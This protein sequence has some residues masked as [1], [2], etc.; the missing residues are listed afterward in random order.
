MSWTNANLAVDA[1][2]TAYER[3]M[4]EKAKSFKSLN[5]STAYDGKRELAKRDIAARLVRM[6]VVLDDLTADNIA[7]LNRTAT[8]REL[9]LIWFDLAERNDTVA[10]DKARRYEELY[11]DSFQDVALAL[12]VPTNTAGITNIPLRRA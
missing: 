5:G 2:L 12:A 6:G 1:D 8:L 7:A 11:E 3:T 9:C 10:M 4:P